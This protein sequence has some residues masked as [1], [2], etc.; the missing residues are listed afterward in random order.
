MQRTSSFYH[1]AAN[2][3]REATDWTQLKFE[4]NSMENN[5]I[6]RAMVKSNSFHCQQQRNNWQDRAMDDTV[7]RKH[8]EETRHL[9]RLN[10]LLT[11]Q[12]RIK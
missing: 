6:E 3:K 7:E 9:I 11:D 8:D 12:A 4:E 2:A 10:Q 5:S 1:S